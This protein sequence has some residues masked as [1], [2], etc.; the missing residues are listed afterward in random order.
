AQ[1]NRIDAGPETDT[2]FFLQIFA[3]EGSPSDTE[4]QF[5]Q[6]NYVSSARQRYDTDSDSTTWET[7]EVTTVVPAGTDFLL[8]GF[9]SYEDKHDDSPED[10]EFLGHYV[11]GVEVILTQLNS[12]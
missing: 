8:I 11:D 4:A 12:N 2:A 3:F 5:D 9:Y 1:F 6:D 7:V 10:L